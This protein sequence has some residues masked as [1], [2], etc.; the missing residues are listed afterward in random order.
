MIAALKL[1]LLAASVLPA[2]AF[3]LISRGLYPRA[4]PR[5]QSDFINKIFGGGGGGGS[6]GVSLSLDFKSLEAAPSWQELEEL[7]AATATGARLAQ[8][9]SKPSYGVGFGFLRACSI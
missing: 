3:S 6:P 7:A 2:A 4:T 1:A 8:M 5:L 9:V